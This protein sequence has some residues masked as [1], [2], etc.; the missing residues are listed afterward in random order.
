[1]KLCSRKHSPQLCLITEGPQ[2]FPLLKTLLSNIFTI[3]LH[4]SLSC[5]CFILWRFVIRGGKLDGSH[6]IWE[7][8]PV[9]KQIK[10]WDCLV[11]VDSTEE[12]RLYF[13]LLA[14]HTE[15]KRHEQALHKIGFLK[16]PLNIMAN[17]HKT[18]CQYTL[19]IK[20]NPTKP[21]W[22]VTQH[23]PKWLNTWQF[24]MLVRIWMDWDPL[25]LLVGT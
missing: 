7:K 6:R 22:D 21:Q 24:H 23:M 25:I 1:M 5:L 2:Q 8:A 4:S 12:R 9:K 20:E 16:W 3:K 17:K 10:F 19:A 11:D 14:Y 13:T 18:G 15:W